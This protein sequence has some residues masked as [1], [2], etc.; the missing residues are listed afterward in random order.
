MNTTPDGIRFVVFKECD[1]WVAQGLEV[2]I[3]VQA[4]DLDTLDARLDVAIDVE[5]E[6][7]HS[8]GKEG[9]GDIGQAPVAFFQMW[10]RGR[11]VA[12]RHPELKLCA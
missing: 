12:S 1:Q 7:A 2:D 6:Y 4:P 9:F 3:C 5:R 11:K 10:E 8:K